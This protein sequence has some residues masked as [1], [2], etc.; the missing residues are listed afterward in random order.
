[1]IPYAH[2]DDDAAF[3]LGLAAPFFASR[4]SRRVFH[5]LPYGTG[6]CEGSGQITPRDREAAIVNVLLDET[7]PAQ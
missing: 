1:M 3:R 4:D 6:V 7:I 5:Q 2:S